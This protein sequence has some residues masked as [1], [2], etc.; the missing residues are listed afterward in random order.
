M[1]DTSGTT[2]ITNTPPTT[3]N[4]VEHL[5]NPSDHVKMKSCPIENT[6]KLPR[7]LDIPANLIE[8]SN[9][10][11]SLHRPFKSPSF[12]EDG[13]LIYDDNNPVS[14]YKNN[15]FSFCL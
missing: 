10:S 11:I 14:S 12:I 13:I 5:I 8:L 2:T 9:C 7:L 15:N 3:K 1:S 4:K 6:F